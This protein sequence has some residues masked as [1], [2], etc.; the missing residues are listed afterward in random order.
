[1]ID[2][3]VGSGTTTAVARK[4]GR[5]WLGIDSVSKHA[6]VARQRTNEELR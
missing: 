4:L 5:H 2:P 6:Q 1:V 3:F